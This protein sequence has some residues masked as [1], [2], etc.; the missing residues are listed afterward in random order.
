M[1]N[2]S[3]DLL[4]TVLKVKNRMVLRVQNSLSVLIVYPPDSVV[5]WELRQAVPAQY[6]KRLSYYI[7]LA[8]DKIKIQSMFS[9][10]C[11]LLLHYLKAEKL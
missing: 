6:H 4:N 7:S 10:E 1:L 8:Q 2:S 5:E 11:I 3:W 9:T